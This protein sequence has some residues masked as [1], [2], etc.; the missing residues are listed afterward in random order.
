MLAIGDSF[1]DWHAD[2]KES[3]PGEVG[4][5]LQVS[6]DNHAISGASF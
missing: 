6:V 3:I 2:S 1:F 5:A 4:K